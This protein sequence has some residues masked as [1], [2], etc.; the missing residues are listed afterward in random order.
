MPHSK[1]IYLGIKGSVIAMDAATGRQL[2]SV[3]LKGG[4]FVNVVLDGD[5][6]YGTTAGEIFCLDRRTGEG[7]WHNKLSGFGYGLISIA[8]EGVAP[9]QNLINAEE[10]N[11]QQE[12]ASSSSGT[13]A[14]GALGQ[15]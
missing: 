1:V 4:S 12:Q 11:R 6:L 14:P 5:N 13:S 9:N 10:F 8:G 15:I 2:W 3:H 7:R